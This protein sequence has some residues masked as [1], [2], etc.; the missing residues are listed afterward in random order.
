MDQ[1]GIRPLQAVSK[2]ALLKVSEKKMDCLNI[3]KR[4]Q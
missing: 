2:V 4:T 1:A 3:S